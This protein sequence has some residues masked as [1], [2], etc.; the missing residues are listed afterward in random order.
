MKNILIDWNSVVWDAYEYIANSAIT[1]IVILPLTCFN[2]TD[3]IIFLWYNLISEHQHAAVKPGFCPAR[4]AG[5][6][7]R[8]VNECS[9]D[10]ECDGPTK[11]CDNGCAMVCRPARGNSHQSCIF[12][13]NESWFLVSC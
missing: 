13:V 9:L 3:E 11:C 6:F 8:C 7:G 4:N 10:T 2:I 5:E 12:L 1:N